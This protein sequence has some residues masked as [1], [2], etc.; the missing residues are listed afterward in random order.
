MR[1]NERYVNDIAPELIRGALTRLGHRF[2]GPARA[3]DVNLGALR[4]NDRTANGGWCDVGWAVFA[5]SPGGPLDAALWCMT[6]APG[7]DY[8]EDP[9]HPDGALVLPT[10]QHGG[11][12]KVGVHRAGKPGARP[13]LV[14]ARPV[15]VW[16]D[17]D[18]D[19]ELDPPERLTA[20]GWFGVNGHDARPQG[21]PTLTRQ[22]FGCSVWRWTED[23]QHALDIVDAQ[24]RANGWDTVSY[25]VVSEDDAPE[26]LALAL[27]V[28]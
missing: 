23:M 25:T 19:R 21:R 24:R 16:R 4:V 2:F 17:S 7:P 12:W 10:G 20:P 15:R 11:L 9:E 5:R 14:Q 27:A 3:Y 28:R 13:A 6:T 26:L 22:S 18:G 1:T 8:L